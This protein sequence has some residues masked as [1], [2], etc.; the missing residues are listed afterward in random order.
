MA[1]T[2]TFLTYMKLQMVIGEC[3]EKVL[4][5]TRSYIEVLGSLWGNESHAGAPWWGIGLFFFV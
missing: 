3:L 1:D 4:P 2:L 5:I